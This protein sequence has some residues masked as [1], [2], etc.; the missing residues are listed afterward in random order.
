MRNAGERVVPGILF[1]EFQTEIS[2]D[3]K[4]FDD[5]FADWK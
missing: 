1:V 2:I 3:E 4:I 5:L